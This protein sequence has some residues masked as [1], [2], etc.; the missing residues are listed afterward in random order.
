M[1]ALIDMDLVCFRCAASAEEDDLGIAIYRMNELLD[2]ILEKTGATEY[3]AF[4][5][6]EDNFRKQIYPEYK[7]NRTQTISTM[8]LL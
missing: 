8:S 4:L 2:Q 6:G 1:I 7:A 3:R 5:T